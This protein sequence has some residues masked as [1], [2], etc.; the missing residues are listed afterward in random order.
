MKQTKSII[1]TNDFKN[2]GITLI[3]LV[4]TIIVLLI[5]AGVSI[6]MLTGENGIL[7]QAQNAKKETEEA[8]E[9]ELRKL[10]ALEAATNLNNTTYKDKNGQTVTI[11]A[12]FAVS[13]VEGENTVEDGLVI[14]DSKGNE[15]VWIPVASEDEYKRNL[16]YEDSNVSKNAY[17]DTN[18][19]PDGMET[20]D[21]T[22]NEIAERDA[23][24][25]KGG[26]YISRY[27][28]GKEGTD[29]LVS[30]SGATV[31]NNIAVEDS[32]E[33][34]GC[35]TVA[36]TF[37]NN[38]NVKSALCSGIQWDVTMSFIDGKNDGKGNV[39]NVKEVNKNRHT[40]LLA[41]SGQNEYDRVCNIYDLEGNCWE[42][43]AEKSL[44]DINYQFVCRGGSY[45]NSAASH[46]FNNSGSGYDDNSFR[47]VLYIIK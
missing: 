29:T 8:Q 18:Y 17:A 45:G 6:S 27:E 19:L 4:I 5:L 15:F 13:K 28:A 9:D 21:S 41:T 24:T 31:W 43:V 2:N 35:K 14:I 25:S 20:G 44:K 3:A 39:F 16:D 33:I 10:T 23:V 42:Y 26:F 7:T 38:N 46:C 30:K 22:N 11:P 47:F 34:K 36:K 32:G 40:N 37:I 12:G 1:K